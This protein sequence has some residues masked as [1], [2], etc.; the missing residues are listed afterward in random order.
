MVMGESMR[1]IMDYVV[2][3]KGVEGLKSMI[4]EINSK[5]VIFTDEKEIK[6]NK[7]YPS[8]YLIRTIKS[9]I[10]VLGDEKKVE[11]MGF[12]FGENMN[13]KF[14][15]FFGTY[16]PKKSTQHIVIYMRKYLP[17]YHTGY[18]SMSENTFWL[19]VSKLNDD[20]IPFIN[21][22]MTKIFERHGGI[23]DVKKKILKGKIEYVIKF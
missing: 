20:V 15:G 22:V 9:A 18:R 2:K 14:R 4:D 21:G 5:S 6:A 11:E 17:I 1:L 3:K 7:K 8:Y 10:K 16:N 19:G 12:Y 13:L 23:K